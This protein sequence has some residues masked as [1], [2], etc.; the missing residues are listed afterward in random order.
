[1]IPLGI[2]GSRGGQLEFLI[3]S[4]PKLGGLSEV[5]VTGINSASVSY[6]A[7]NQ[8]GVDRFTYAVRSAEGVS[9]P[10]IV[11][12]TISEPV[13][14]PAQLTLPERLEF[15]TVVAGQRSSAVLEIK[16]TGGTTAEGDITVPPPWVIEEG[17]RYRVVAGGTFRATIAFTPEKTG[18]ASADAVVSGTPAR[19]V[20]LSGEAVEP[21]AFS[22]ATL[23]LQA[24]PG[25]QTRKAV[26]KIANRTD[27]ERVVSLGPDKRLITGQTVT[28][29]AKGSAEIPVFA[30][31]NETGAFDAKLQ[32]ASDKWSAAVPVHAAAMGA[33][34][35][36]TA[37]EVPR[38]SIAGQ[39]AEAV[40]VVSNSGATDASIVA[41]AGP[42]IETPGGQIRVEAGKSATVNVRIPRPRA[43]DFSGEVTIEGAGQK[44][45]HVIAFAV[46]EK[47]APEPAPAVRP[48]ADPP[49]GV[50]PV[51]PAP[52]P[53]PLKSVTAAEHPNGRGRLGRAVSP[54]TAVIEWP[55]TFGATKG[56]ALQRR[57]A[58]LGKGGAISESWVAGPPVVFKEEGGKIRAEISKLEPGQLQA[59]RVVGSGGAALLTVSFTTPHKQPLIDIGWRGITLILLFGTLAAF[60]WW[61]WK[62]RVRSA[63]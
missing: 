54:T 34:L 3:R 60:G 27:E 29:R 26:L 63:W 32:L 59:L 44:L 1:M 14:L 37:V 50:K 61:K 4:S 9:A 15:P 10:G 33:V 35:Q 12:V 42:A 28:I 46:A 52:G 20:T 53:P 30:D 40:L 47:A 25:N 57:V 45:S 23:E 13:V 36:I 16:N 41:R 56:L 5:A 24:S 6:T 43:G 17:G 62:T 2:H 48:K 38:Q 31:A 8:P 39:P 7:G 58:S 22:P 18:P 19:M 49:P 51:A 55:A 21:L 11:T